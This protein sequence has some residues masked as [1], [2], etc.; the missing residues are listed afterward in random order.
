M[1][2]GW[3]L[4]WIIQKLSKSISKLNEKKTNLNQDQKVETQGKLTLHF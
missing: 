2:G 1:A 4:E 3:I